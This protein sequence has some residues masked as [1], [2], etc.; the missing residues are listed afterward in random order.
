MTIAIADWRRYGHRNGHAASLVR[1]KID[2]L[3]GA[4]THV[5]HGISVGPSDCKIDHL[6]IA[7]GGVFAVITREE[8]SRDVRVDGY[9]MTAGAA[10]VPHLRNA[11]FAAERASSLLTAHADFDVPVRACLV[12]LTGPHAPHI[13]VESRPLGVSVL[14]KT[15]V[16]RFFRHQPAILTAEQ[17]WDIRAI[18]RRSSTWA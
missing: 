2:D 3:A 13:T 12:L 7:C 9:T 6:I 8:A 5:L 17:V 11:K 15:D 4:E 18:A 16:P 10:K 1:A 14:T